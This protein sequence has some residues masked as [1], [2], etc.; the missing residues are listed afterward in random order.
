MHFHQMTTDDEEMQGKEEE[1]IA[2]T[3]PPLLKTIY[4]ILH[5]RIIQKKVEMQNQK[6]QIKFRQST[7]TDYQF[8][9]ALNDGTKIYSTLN[10]T[11]NV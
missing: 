6:P 1:A 2:A 4:D 5:N 11:P 10:L 7:P 9:I 3:R 8:I